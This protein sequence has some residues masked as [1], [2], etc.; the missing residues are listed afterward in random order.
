MAKRP[1]PAPEE[2][3]FDRFRDLAKKVISAPKPE[4]PATKR[5]RKPKTRKNLNGRRS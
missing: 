1:P 3:P 2:T 4:S 5:A